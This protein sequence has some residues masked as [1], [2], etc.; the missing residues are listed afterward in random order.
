MRQQKRGFWLVVA[1]LIC[2]EYRNDR[3]SVKD[4]TY[5]DTLLLQTPPLPSPTDE[6]EHPP[7]RP[8]PS[9]SLAILLP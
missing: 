7:P 3:R 6:L 4:L 8:P 1:C 2:M 9:C 5:N